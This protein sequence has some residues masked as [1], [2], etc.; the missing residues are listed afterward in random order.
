[1]L[2][3]SIH[4]GPDPIPDDGADKGNQPVEGVAV[5]R[6]QALGSQIE[7]QYPNHYAGHR[8]KRWPF[9][10]WSLWAHP[11]LSFPPLRSSTFHSRGDALTG[12]GAVVSRRIR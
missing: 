9:G 12:P 10:C 3:Q 11:G 6:Q 4:T 2:F 7:S 1:M 8:L 5:T